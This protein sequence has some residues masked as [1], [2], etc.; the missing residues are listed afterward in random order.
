MLVVLS[1]VTILT[2]TLLEGGE[3]EPS[4]PVYQIA[5]L[6]W[7]GALLL[8]S[9]VILFAWLLITWQARFFDQ[10]LALASPH[11]ALHTADEPQ[12]APVRAQE[13]GA[14]PPF[15]PRSPI[16]DDLTHIEGI[17][18]VISRLLQSKGILTFSQLAQIDPQD[19][20]RFIRE[21][22]LR[23]ANT[24]TWSEQA[25]LAALGDFDGLRAYQSRLKSGREV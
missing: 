12:A 6:Y 1:Y 4:I 20:N 14:P 8:I 18:P 23:L 3:G 7:W 17:G 22:N 21:A 19:L 10:Q 25:R 11:A 5:S 24:S 16:P 13:L 2:S 9:L 15:P